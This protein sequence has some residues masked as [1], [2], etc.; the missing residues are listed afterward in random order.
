MKH[1]A[2]AFLLLAAPAAQAQTQDIF[3][4]VTSTQPGS[5]VSV[6]IDPALS[7]GRLVLRIA[8]QNRT[9]APIK[10]G[11]ADIRI[12]QTTGEAVALTPL[13]TLIADVRR[14]AGSSDDG[15]GVSAAMQ[16]APAMTTT[17]TGQKD[18]SGYTGNMGASG[19][20]APRNNRSAGP[21][22]PEAQAQIA[23]LEAGILTDATIAPGDILARQAVTQ[24][25]KF[26]KASNR[27][28]IVSISVAG[29]IH[30]F[31]FAAPKR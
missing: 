28:L 18:V 12:V 3:T 6:S 24:K 17:N 14:A 29:E 4:G 31:S 19:V 26:R 8:V 16:S 1:F 21:L 25:L 11:P 10:F 2:L 20:V 15:S 22:P 30:N 27:D 23:G 7:D 9:G 5:A 13:D